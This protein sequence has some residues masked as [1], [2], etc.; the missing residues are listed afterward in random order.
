MDRNNFFNRFGNG[1]NTTADLISSIHI[2]YHFYL[3]GELSQISINPHQIPLIQYLN[4]NEK[5]SQDEVADFLFLSK[6]T[7]AKI[8][9][10]LEDEGIIEREVNQENRRKNDVVLS[11]KGKELATKIEKIDEK[12]Q[13]EIYKDLSKEEVE[14]VEEAIKKMVKNSEEII[15]NENYDIWE[16]RREKFQDLHEK[17]GN[18]DPRGNFPHHNPPEGFNPFH[19]PFPR[20]RGRF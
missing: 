1:R 10:K 9:R 11:E 13:N 20:F 17:Y 12:W 15:K 19:H 14:K 3:M 8:L 4:E 6:G 16:K 18:D 5:A 2:N 7:V